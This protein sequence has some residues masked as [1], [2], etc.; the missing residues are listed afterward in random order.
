MI[1]LQK[2]NRLLEAPVT[3]KTPPSFTPAGSSYIKATVT[4]KTPTSSF[5]T[6]PP[7]LTAIDLTTQAE[8]HHMRA[9]DLTAQTESPHL[10]AADLTTAINAT[11]S[12]G[13]SASS[14]HRTRHPMT[15]LI[16]EDFLVDLVSSI[17]QSQENARETRK[18]EEEV[19]EKKLLALS[20]IENVNVVSKSPPLAASKESLDE[21]DDI[22]DSELIQLFK[23]ISVVQRLQTMMK[24]ARH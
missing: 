3:N 16:V 4:S 1:K 5:Q 12:S 21:S 10:K 17:V 9:T 23:G 18:L 8:S 13:F 20:L 7:H 14:S 19:E 6:R 2:R 11:K 15:E 22:R 24:T